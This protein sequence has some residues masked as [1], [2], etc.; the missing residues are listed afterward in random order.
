MAKDR[1][2]VT[3]TVPQVLEFLTILASENKA[4][5]TIKGYI[6]AIARRHDLV[7]GVP[8]G[9]HPLVMQWSRG[10]G[11]MRPMA[12]PVLPSWRL[13]LVLAALSK[14]PFEPIRIADMKFLTWKT[15]FL[16]AITSARRVSELQALCYLEPY[17]VF[18]A[19]NVTMATNSRFVPKV[20]SAFH[21]S[22]LIQ[23]PAMHEEDSAQLR[24]LCV[25]RSLVH[26]IERT[27]KYR[28]K[29]GSDQLFLTYG[30]GRST[31]KGTPVSKVRL[32]KWIVELIQYAYEELGLAAPQGVKAH[33]TRAQAT[34]W[35]ALVGVEPR[36]ICEAA[37]WSSSCTFAKHYSLDLFHRANCEFGSMILR[38]ASS[39]SS[40]SL[41]GYTIP[42][43]VR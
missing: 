1:D 32:S 27:A 37:T 38:S 24:S 34:S 35:A 39:T 21:T 8:L 15:V 9:C 4:T 19:T 20:N 40:S 42:K 7:E 22:Q 36:K 3:E 5:S 12:A 2:P 10:L 18:R 16:I 26:Y 41:K 25:R 6:T 11:Q 31:P 13:E 29:Q 43:K 17:T 28:T 30:G 23:L 14:P 33:S